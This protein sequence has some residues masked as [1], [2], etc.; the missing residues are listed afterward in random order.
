MKWL[1]EPQ[2]PQLKMQTRC[3]S[4]KQAFAE[5]SKHQQKKPIYFDMLPFYDEK[6]LNW[7]QLKFAKQVKTGERPTPT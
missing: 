5:W 7:Q 6:S 1:V 2:W 4:A 3:E